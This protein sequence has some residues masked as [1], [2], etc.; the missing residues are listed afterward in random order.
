MQVNSKPGATLLGFKP[1]VFHLPTMANR[2]TW[3][4]HF[5]VS[6]ALK[7]SHIVEFWL[8]VRGKSDNVPHPGLAPQTLPWSP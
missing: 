6:L 3:K 5:S 7:C 2:C 1:H 4:L 8:A